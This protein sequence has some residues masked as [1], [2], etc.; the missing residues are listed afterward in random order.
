[1]KAGRAF[2]QRVMLIGRIAFST[3]STTQVP[4]NQWVHVCAMV[5][6]GQ[7]VY[8]INGQPAGTG[9]SGITL[10]GAADAENVVIGRSQEGANRSFLGMIDD[11]RI[12]NRA[13]TQVEVQEAMLGGDIQ[14]ASNPNPAHL[15]VD[16][17]I[18]ANLSWRRGDGALQDEVYFGTDPCALPLVTTIQNLPPFPPDWNPPG[19][20]IASTT[21]Y[22]Q[23]VEVNNLDR[24]PS[25][26]WEFTTIS[27]AAQ[28]D[29]P[30]DGAVIVGDMAGANI[31]TK[32][33]FVPGVTAVSHVGYFS[34]DYSK[35]ESRDPTVWLGPPPY[36][37]TPGW[38]YT[39]FAGNPSVPPVTDTLVR[40]TRYYWTVDANDTLN[41]E[42][43]GDVW[44][45][46]IQ[47]YKAFAPS[48]PNEAVLISTDVLLS[49]L[50]GFVV[51]DHDIYMGTSWEDVNNAVYHPTAAP[52]EFVAT[53]ADPNFQTSGLPGDTKLYW[54]VDQVVGRFPPPIGGGTYYKGDVWCFTTIPVFPITDPNLTG[55]WTFDMGIGTMAWDNSGYENHGTLMGDPQW[56]ASMN[57]M[58]DGAMDFDGTDD[59]IFTGK[60]AADLGISGNHPKTVTAWVFTREFDNGG[61][62][63]VGTRANSQEYCLRTTTTDNLW[64]I[65]FWG[66]QGV[67]DLDFSYPTLNQWVHFGL[68]Y[69]STNSPTCSVYGNAQYITGF[70]PSLNVSNANPFQIG[71]YGW[72]NDYFNG[73]IDDVRVYDYALTADEI[74]MLGAPPEAWDPSPYDG[75]ASVPLGTP[76]NWMPGKYAAQHDVYFGTDKDAVTNA[77]VTTPGIYLGRIGPNTLPVALAAAEFYYW[78]VDE[79]NVAGPAPNLWKG[80]TWTFRTVGAAGGLLGLYYHWDGQLP[81]DPLGPDNAFQIFVMSRIDPE[82]NFGWGNG[83]PDPNINVEDFAARWVGHVECPVD[84]NYTFYTT[85]DDGA[86]LFINGVKMPLVNPAA[87]LNDAWRQQ[88]DTQYG[89]EI[90]LT[91][92]LHDIEMHMYERAGGATARLA[93]SAIPTNPS[94]YPVVG[95]ST[96]QQIIPAIW[97]WPPLF[98]SGPRPPDGA[99][100]DERAP[101]LEWIAG[102]NADYHELYFSASFDDVNN[103]NPAIKQITTADYDRPVSSLS[104]GPGPTTSIRQDLLLACR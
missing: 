68:T 53:R 23:I 13:L 103:R 96:S 11:A 10:P 41:N 87:P 40:G 6:G 89:A 30:F 5:V 74:R 67:D 70:N 22:W 20:L 56:V 60:S 27:G 100:I 99:T 9:G 63:D 78:R 57:T 54:R 83:S 48:P 82:V 55:W 62:F 47:G 94:D 91:A 15:A 42:F 97:L 92:G 69:D 35:V 86:R 18:D 8:Y 14:E 28:C 77:T 102:V 58:L 52:P 73:I 98:A 39:L 59:Y 34:D 3:S 104:G 61:I 1:M 12:Y 44:S 65:Q 32:L 64:R 19:D 71:C 7:H 93:W 37:G 49:W 25:N 36:A 21:Y 17:P 66:A 79:V 45:F 50:P 72:Q 31:W 24:Y 80:S 2:L 51:E 90:V 29:Y 76:L 75:Q 85:T 33:I 46:A 43:Y 26:I 88:G 4:L 38:E 101:A 16:V 84:A 95:L 81:N